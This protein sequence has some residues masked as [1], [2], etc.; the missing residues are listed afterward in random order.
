MDSEAVLFFLSQVVSFKNCAETVLGRSVFISRQSQLDSEVWVPIVCEV[1]PDPAAL[2]PAARAGSS[3]GE[4]Q[5]RVLDS[6]CP[7]TLQGGRD[8][9]K[10]SQGRHCTSKSVLSLWL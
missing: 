5:G 9:G 7:G 10:G 4:G 1:N 2:R 6:G 3:E 8:E